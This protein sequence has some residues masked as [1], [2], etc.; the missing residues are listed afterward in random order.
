[1]PEADIETIPGI[2]SFHAASARLNRILVEGE[3]SLLVTSGAFGGDRIRH[4]DGVE[5]V[6]IVKAYKNIKDINKALKETGLSKKCVAV[7]KCGRKNE[8]IIEN[9][10]A[11]EKRTPDYWTLIL[12]SK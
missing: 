4:I 6:A 8:Q 12:A 2:T 10:D 3:E 9:I 11:L 1:M 7:S 5:N